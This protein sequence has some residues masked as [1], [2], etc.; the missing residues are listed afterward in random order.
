MLP[1]NWDTAI[2]ICYQSSYG[3]VISKFGGYAP[4]VCQCSGWE[5]MM[6][7]LPSW[8]FG[9]LLR[10][11]SIHM[12]S[13]LSRPRLLTLRGVTVLNAQL[14]STNSTLTYVLGWSRCVRAVLTASSVHLLLEDFHLMLLH[15]STQRQIFNSLLHYICLTVLVTFNFSDD[16]FLS[17]SYPVKTMNLQMCWCW[18]FVIWYDFPPSIDTFWQ[19]NLLWCFQLFNCQFILSSSNI[20]HVDLT[21]VSEYLEKWASDHRA[22]F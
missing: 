18:T 10:K 15:V 6:C 12:H 14:K 9:L 13:E 7:G 8:R 2:V 21:V 19:L 3:R 4:V 1:L 20:S 16:S 17:P 5:W 11:S 22:I